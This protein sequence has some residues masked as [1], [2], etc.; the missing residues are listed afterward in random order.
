M[1]KNKKRKREAEAAVKEADTEAAKAVVK[2]LA[3]TEAALKA[4][5]EYF[6]DIQNPE[7]EREGNMY[8]LMVGKLSTSQFIK[9]KNHILKVYDATTGKRYSVDDDTDDDATIVPGQYKILIIIYL[10][11][12]SFLIYE[13]DE[14]PNTSP[15]YSPTQ[16][17][18]QEEEGQYC[19][20]SPTSPTYIPT[21]THYTDAE[22]EE[23]AKESEIIVID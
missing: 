8:M 15:R 17:E 23:E 4:L 1:L 2:A 12:I 18:G 5:I 3:D 6:D 22:K 13:D 21:T 9:L 11:I 19:P 16:A 14:E 7:R 10:L 20:Y